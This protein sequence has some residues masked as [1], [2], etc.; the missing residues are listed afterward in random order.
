MS[1]FGDLL[2][3]TDSQRWRWW[4][5][6]AARGSAWDFLDSFPSVVDRFDSD[7]SLAPVVFVIGRS[8]RGHIHEEE[9]EIFDDEEDFEDRIGPANRAIAFFIAQCSAARKAVDAWCLMAVRINSKANRDIRKKIGM[10]I[11][12]ARE[13]AD[14]AVAA[15]AG[16]KRARIEISE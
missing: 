5:P 3:E 1:F 6:A 2:D 14:Y 13:H 8:L 11:W 16:L 15:D 12:E 10:I 9:R 7:S 4:G